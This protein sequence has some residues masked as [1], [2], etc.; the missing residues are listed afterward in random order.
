MLDSLALSVW[1]LQQLT[2]ERGVPLGTLLDV[3]VDLG[4]SQIE[5]N[6][7][8]VRLPE[9]RHLAGMRRLR[10]ELE[11][12]GLKL[13]STWFYTDFLG[14]VRISSRPAL[15][16]QLREYLLTAAEL[17]AE[18]LTLPLGD[19]F[20]GIDVDK[21]RATLNEILVEVL[22]LAEATGVRIG[23]ETGRSEGTFH[24]PGAVL[25]LVESFASPSL[26]MVPDFEAWRVSTS[27]LPLMHVETQAASSEPAPV[28]LFRAC[29]PYAPIVHAK[30][31]R[32][33][34]N[35]DEPHFPLRE[36][37]AA[38]VESPIRHILEVEYEGW[39][40]DVD[41]HLD[42]I[43]QTRQCL[44]LLRRMASHAIPATSLSAATGERGVLTE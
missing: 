42:C 28:S 13:L 11:S 34:E 1:S 43:E 9:Y 23:I 22:P 37:M 14:T 2:L 18:Q 6:E 15:V 39:I 5:L 30:L 10:A 7:D 20:D 41:P 31:L 17:G 4:V 27:D 24:T 44:S 40:P 32:L 21:G 8:Y 33:D 36:L 29:L 38:I 12:R 3:I 35:G 19:G 26:R 16:E 25:R